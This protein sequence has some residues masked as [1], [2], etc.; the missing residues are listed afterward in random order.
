MSHDRILTNQLDPK[1]AITIISRLTQTINKQNKQ[2][3]M[4][5]NNIQLQISYFEN[6]IKLIKSSKYYHFI[7][8]IKS[9]IL[10]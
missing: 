10:S 6:N 4:E 5:I 1:Q 9:T 7:N 3:L 8:F 2:L